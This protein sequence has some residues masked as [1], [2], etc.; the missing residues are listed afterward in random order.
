MA[1]AAAC[2][3]DC[4]V[5]VFLALVLVSSGQ[6]LVEEPDIFLAGCSSPASLGFRTIATCVILIAC[7][8]S[9][10]TKLNKYQ[11]TIPVGVISN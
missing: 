7:S 11:G 1:A 5:A 9:T 3:A 10:Y 2:G 4:R 6:A 8:I